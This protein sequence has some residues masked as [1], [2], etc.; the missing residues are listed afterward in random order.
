MKR[1]LYTIALAFITSSLFA[2]SFERNY[3]I[4]VTVD[5]ELLENP[6]AGGLNSCQVS[7]ID[8]N[9][10]G[11]KDIFIFDRIGS[12][13]SIFINMDPTPGVINYKY[14][15][16]YNHLFPQG[17]RNWVLLRDMNCDG[18]ED[19]CSNV[20]S[21][22]RIYFNTSQTSLQFSANSG[23]IQAYYDFGG[24]PFVNTVYCIAP[25]IPAINDYDGDG[26]MDIWSWNEY[27]TAMYFYK[28]M[29][30][31]NGDC[32]TVDYICRNR[33]YGQFG[34]SPESFTLFLG[35]E[36]VCDFNVVNP[37]GAI[38]ESGLHTGGTSLALDLDQDGMRDLVIG[39]VTENF[40]AALMVDESI[41]GQDSVTFVHYD[42]PAAFNSTTPGAI[43][44]FPAAFYEDVNNDGVH[45]LWI[46]TNSYS[47][48]ADKHSLLLYLNNG[49][50]N[51]PDFS[52]V[53]DDFFQSE[54]IDL[55]TSAYPVVFDVNNDGL[56]DL[57]VS[58]RKYFDLSNQYTSQ[59]WYFRNTGTAVAP[60][61]TLAD[62]N[63]MNMP[64][65]EWQSVYPAFGD[66]DGDGDADM[67]VGDQDGELHHFINAAVSGAPAIFT[68]ATDP[69]FDVNNE[70]IDVGQSVVPQIIDLN[71][72]GKNDLIIGELNGNVNYYQN[73]GT[74]A[75]FVFTHVADSIGGAIATNVLGIQGK[76][77][78]FFF[79]NSNDEFELI[80]GTE[81]GQ[82]NHYNNISGNLNGTF[83]LVTNDFENIKE[84]DRG[85]VFLS[86]IT[87][88]GQYDL[89]VGNI[90]G[91]V[92][93]Y[94]HLPVGVDS[95]ISSNPLL[96][97][98][99]PANDFIR[100]ELPA[101]SVL[102]ASID[103]LDCSGRLVKQTT[104]KS[105]NENIMVDELSS[106]VYLVRIKT[107]ARSF[108]GRFLKK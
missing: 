74:V 26:D 7:R 12:R 20:G 80:L 25:D 93:I 21:G 89:F 95:Y 87:N 108:S 15:R 96:I 48:A 61:F 76:S 49:F 31:E 102:P 56:K 69:L 10:D 43:T 36:F 11:A 71:E 4:P 55:G 41:S 18:K 64:F 5:G 81:T 66:L 8:V 94:T 3:N 53:Q 104:M 68:L 84:G 23:N 103:I 57:L 44:T 51:L 99:N 38:L 72:D 1:L 107:E 22:F 79:K 73:T 67:I 39:D 92:G 34:E 32:N 86:D 28:N 78:P 33:C 59:I 47:D 52:F 63:W 100:I 75:N 90:A 13:I 27:S 54:M 46:S 50:N 58:N 37:R 82:I 65:Y 101:S 45:D 85:S 62:D 40:P 2:Q 106:G 42:F 98:P 17:L 91:G 105:S 30:V 24:D 14:T 6:W 88:D 29:A 16:A 35:D 70:L 60:A 9:L 83:N 19:I 97:F 77:V